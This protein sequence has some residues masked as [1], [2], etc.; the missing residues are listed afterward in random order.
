MD[1]VI[2]GIYDANGN[3][4]NG[5]FNDD[6]GYLNYNSYVSYT[7]ESTGDY[8]I[9][10]RAY[11]NYTGDYSLSV[12]QAGEVIDDFSANTNTSGMVTIDDLNGLSGEIEQSYDV[13]WVK[14][15]VN[16][17]TTYEVKVE[18]INNTII[19]TVISGIYDSDGIYIPGT[20]DDDSGEGL[21]SLV[22]F[23]P[24]VSGDYFIGIRG[25]GSRDGE[26]KV[27][28]TQEAQIVDDHANTVNTVFDESI[29][30]NITEEV[31]VKEGTLG[32]SSDE[33]IFK[34]DVVNGESYIISLDSNDSSW[35]SMN[36]LDENGNYV[37]DNIYWPWSSSNSSEIIFTPTDEED[38]FIKVQGLEAS[39]YTLS[40]QREI[41]NDD[42]ADTINGPFDD[43]DTFS[44]IS[45]ITVLGGELETSRD[46]DVFKLEVISGESYEVNLLS[47]ESNSLYMRV[48]DQ[49]DNYVWENIHWQWNE[50]SI[51][52]FIFTA[53][54]TSDYFIEVD[55]WELSTYNI[56]VV[57]L[58]LENDDHANS[59]EE[60]TN[61]DILIVDTNSS[62]SATSG[63]LET[64]VDV[65]FFKFTAQANTTY[66][67][68]LD[69]EDN[70]WPYLNIYDS[71]GNYQWNN[72]EWQWD[73]DVS[74]KLFFTALEAGDFFI[75]VDGWESSEYSIKVNQLD[76]IV[77]DFVNSVDEAALTSSIATDG[78]E[79]VGSLETSHDIDIFKISVESGH[80]YEITL[81]TNDG[82]WPYLD[83]LD[84]NSNYQW[85]DV[86][87]EWDNDVTSRV[88]FTPGESGDFYI[89]VDSWEES[90]Y[91][92]SVNAIE[93]NNIADDTTTTASV[94]VDDDIGYDGSLEL[95]DDIDWI[96]VTLQKDV[97]YQIDVS[98]DYTD[99]IIDG[100]YDANG[101]YISNTYDDDSGSWLDARVSFSAEDNGTYYIAVS[102]YSIGEY[103]IQVSTI[104]ELN[105]TEGNS[106]NTS[107]SIEVNNSYEG[108]IDYT[109]DEDWIRVSLEEN[110]TYNINLTGNTLR[111][112][113]IQ[114]IYDAEGNFIDG[115]YND[116][117]G[118]TL[119]SSIT[120]SAT[121]SSD[122]YIVV[123]GYGS[124]TGTY[125]LETQVVQNTDASTT[126]DADD[127]NSDNNGTIATA[128]E[129]NQ[130]GEY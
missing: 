55:G 9:S 1:T 16:A 88:T 96:A 121:E 27:T 73:Y 125:N 61:D 80:S 60:I 103:N 105:D 115:T 4:I 44:D 6:I 63:S 51:E 104:D 128:I 70:T 29:F 19:D 74:D 22:L 66:E 43:T 68:I 56:E 130:L 49:E 77:D 8:Y 20:Y 50:D 45:D 79:I 97:I 15:S 95:Y 127:S 89:Q 21:N 91:T 10:V 69:T 7:A 83:I 106:I 94:V 25:Y 28:V 42:H 78:T 122:Y 71:E 82:S 12:S 30:T 101:T 40:V 64:S 87:W 102:G 31:I 41:N 3:Y 32:T 99:M 113:V 36:I 126:E 23:T 86:Q 11:G 34:L 93:I 118:W 5:T 33:D 35:L 110:E 38:Y 119:D 18:D 100:I 81:D 58:D 39:D 14:I 24:S 72:V 123:S 117:S 53:D 46:R 13:D 84:S 52:S 114:G 116:D 108:S 85:Q 54:E 120:F 59:I 98:S 26:Y 48:L 112:T 47:D 57:K 37:W 17:N 111:D 62:L 76:T 65:D 124:N 109:Y 75:K 92:L 107:V 67:I 2:H 129:E 90:A